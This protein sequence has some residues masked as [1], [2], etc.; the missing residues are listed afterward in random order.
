MML[1]LYSFIGTLEWPAAPRKGIIISGYP[2]AIKRGGWHNTS[3]I[4]VSNHQ[5]K[6]NDGKNEWAGDIHARGADKE[7][8]C[9]RAGKRY[10][11]FGGE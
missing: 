6:N 9:D 7:F 10:F 8:Y 5:A 1:L 11:I 2:L 3:D 4:F